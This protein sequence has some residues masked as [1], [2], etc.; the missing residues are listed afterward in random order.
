ML[1]TMSKEDESR[2]RRWDGIAYEPDPLLW[3]QLERETPEEVCRRALVSY[4]PEQGFL[5]PFLNQIFRIQPRT[6]SIVP[7]YTHG[8]KIKSFELDLIILTYLVR[9][10]ATPLIHAP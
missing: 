1:T 9:A 4:S 10:Q 5:L 8:P 2:Q 7:L 6:R 3:V